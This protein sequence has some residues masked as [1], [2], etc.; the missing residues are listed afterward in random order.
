MG[1]ITY[2][3]TNSNS[4]FTS[5]DMVIVVKTVGEVTQSC[6]LSYSLYHSTLF[7]LFGEY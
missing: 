3:N 4:S 7:T 5:V 2:P 1:T 6:S